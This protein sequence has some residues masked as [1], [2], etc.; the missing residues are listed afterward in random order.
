[1]LN[2]SIGVNNIIDVKP[3]HSNAQNHMP[4]TNN[5]IRH[6][7]NPIIRSILPK[8]EYFVRYNIA[9]EWITKFVQ[10]KKT[11]VK[12]NQSGT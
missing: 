2:I 12:C 5:N 8:I 3:I 10:N 1:M 9:K 4:F 6:A 7:N 11:V